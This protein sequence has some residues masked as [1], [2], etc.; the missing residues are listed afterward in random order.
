MECWERRCFFYCKMKMVPVIGTKRFQAYNPL[1][2]RL[3][4][5]IQE[6]SEVSGETVKSSVILM[7]CF[8]SVPKRC[9]IWSCFCCWLLRS[10]LSYV[11]DFNSLYLTDQ[12]VFPI[13]SIHLFLLALK[14]CNHSILAALIKLSV[15]NFTVFVLFCSPA[16][17]PF[18][19]ELDAPQ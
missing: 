2:L 14:V 7:V 17:R 6:Y 11:I 1:K 19:L 9:A 13:P 12:L 15:A 8:V 18:L 5:H 3:F 16:P 4:H 10:C